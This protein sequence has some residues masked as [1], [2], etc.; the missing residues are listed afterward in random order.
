MIIEAKSSSIDA[1][2]YI[3]II[4]GNKEYPADYVAIMKT[5]REYF[6]MSYCVELWNAFLTDRT[7]F[8]TMM[9]ERYAEKTQTYSER[10]ADG[11]AERVVDTLCNQ[12]L[13][14]FKK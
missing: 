11:V 14:K 9:F 12:P 6:T 1:M 7:L 4:Q 13:K 10:V 8:A 5:I 2:D 3:E